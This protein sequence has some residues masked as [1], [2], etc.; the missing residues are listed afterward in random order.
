MARV[1]AAEAAMPKFSAI[2]IIFYI[3]NFFDPR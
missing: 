3:E 2:A 1:I